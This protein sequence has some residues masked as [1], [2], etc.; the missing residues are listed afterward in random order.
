MLLEFYY[1]P[2]RLPVRRSM[3]PS[4]EFSSYCWASA[5]FRHEGE[6]R[7]YVFNPAQYHGVGLDRRHRAP[8][9]RSPAAGQVKVRPLPRHQ[10]TVQ[11]VMWGESLSYLVEAHCDWT[12]HTMKCQRH[13]PYASQSQL[14]EAIR[15]G[16]G[17]KVMGGEW[18][19]VQ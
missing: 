16:V 13:V 8:D 18:R 5:R 11:L 3:L 9:R 19:E 10:V 14:C 7:P 2:Q 12:G 15:E 17:G 1:Q 6:E 4:G